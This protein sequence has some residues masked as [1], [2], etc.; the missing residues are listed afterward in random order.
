[1]T[2]QAKRRFWV[3]SPNV[4]NNSSTVSK[5]R[6]ASVLWNAAF[7]GYSPNDRKH[8]Q[9]G[10]RFAHVIKP[11][12][13]LLIARRH[14]KEAEIVGF[15]IVQGSFVTRLKGFDPPQSFRSLRNLKPFRAQ[16]SVPLSLNV[17]ESLGSIAALHELHPKSN[18]SHERIC[19]WMERKLSER[20]GSLRKKSERTEGTLDGIEIGLLPNDNELEY[21]TRTARTVIRAKKTE[22]KLLASYRDWLR[23]QQRKLW[24]VKYKNLKCDAYEEERNNLLEAKCST[25]REYIRMAVGQLLDYAYLGRKLLSKPHMAV[26]LPEK[27]DSK[28]CAWLSSLHIS[29]TWKEKEVFLDNANGQFS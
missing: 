10:Y 17:M 1:M 14:K 28:L 22:A 6:Q 20:R 2:Y 24:L 5:W 11:G 25:R 3:V 8:N 29:V 4:R 26:L 23:I 15:G 19:N 13:V 21:E 18:P 9:S 27:P 16:T 7:M 12:D